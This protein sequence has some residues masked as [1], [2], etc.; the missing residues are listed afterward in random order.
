MLENAG[1]DF[2]VV[3]AE[4]DERH[5]EEDGEFTPDAGA[6]A[7]LWLAK[8]KARSVSARHADTLVVGA[9]QT[10]IHNGR[11]L[12]KP[13]DLQDARQQ[14]ITL[15]GQIHQLHAAAVIVR[16]QK[17]CWS[18]VET[19]SL[20]MRNFSEPELDEVLRLEGGENLKSVGAYR[21]EGP[22]VRLF[23]KIDGDYFTILGLP[24]LPL[25]EG[26]RAMGLNP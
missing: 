8:A 19:A 17:V 9:D 25:L 16:D 24:L 20:T 26:L 5:L 21:L 13:H 10:L 18:H 14:L 12:H 23:E 4:I 1:F 7:A 22:S 15:R 2:T 11:P 6:G 3:P